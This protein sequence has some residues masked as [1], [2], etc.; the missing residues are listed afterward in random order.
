MGNAP[1]DSTFRTILIAAE[2]AE[3]LINGARPRL[4]SSFTKPATI[5]LDELERGLV[6]WRAVSADE[7]EQLRLQKL[8]ARAV[9]EHVP[10]FLRPPLP[11]PLPP[12]EAVE[13]DEEPL[14]EELDEDFEDGEFDD[15]E[16]VG[17]DEG[18]TGGAGP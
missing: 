13:T 11:E 5:A 2:R 18:E 16:D 1:V 10:V 12:E 3:Q 7:Y 15:F 9:E 4:V 17:E 8:E 14:D 6:P